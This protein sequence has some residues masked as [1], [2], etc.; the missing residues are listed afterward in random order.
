MSW[1][2]CEERRTWAERDNADV[3]ELNAYAA[4]RRFR[5]LILDRAEMQDF[6]HLFPVRLFAPGRGFG[7]AAVCRSELMGLK[8]RLLRA[9]A[10]V[11]DILF[12]RE[13]RP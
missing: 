5:S 11:L 9:Q 2:R 1:P 8:W 7:L 10:G 13:S 4:S 12:P 6:M 3:D